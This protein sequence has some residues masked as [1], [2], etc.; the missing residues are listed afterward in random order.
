MFYGFS[1]AIEYAVYTLKNIALF[2]LKNINQV[3]V[4]IFIAFF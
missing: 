3:V 1:P 2:N 4:K